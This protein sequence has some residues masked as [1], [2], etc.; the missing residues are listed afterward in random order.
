MALQTLYT[1]GEGKEMYKDIAL[2]SILIYFKIFITFVRQSKTCN[3]PR[4]DALKSRTRV[5]MG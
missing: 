3:I 5:L 2:I 1:F 4:K